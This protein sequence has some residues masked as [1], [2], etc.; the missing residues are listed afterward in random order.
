MGDAA[1][2]RNTISYNSAPSLAR[3]GAEWQRYNKAPSLAKKVR[4]GST[5]CSYW[6]SLAVQPWAETHLLFVLAGFVDG[7]LAVRG[8]IMG[9]AAAERNTI[10]I[11]VFC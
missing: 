3:K 11:L 7:G 4:N 10:S 9:N 6:G 5:H 1:G 8:W 2:G